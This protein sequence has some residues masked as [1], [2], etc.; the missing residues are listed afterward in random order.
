MHLRF[1]ILI[2]YT[3]IELTVSENNSNI[4]TVLSEIENEK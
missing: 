4:K 3:T 1:K 2:Y